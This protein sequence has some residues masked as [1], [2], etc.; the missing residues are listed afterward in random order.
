MSKQPYIGLRPFERDETD[1]FFGREQHSDELVN[2]LGANHFLA[3]IG[4]SG[5]GKSSLVKT[6]LIAGLEAGYLATTGTHWRIVEM[7]PGNRPFKELAEKLEKV[8]ADVL[9]SQ[10]TAET[11]QQTLRQGSLSLHEL[12]A[13]HPLPDKA[14][15]LIVCDQFEEIFRYSQQGANYEAANFVSL[16]LA[17]SKPYPISPKQLS[18]S[19]YVVMTMRSDFLGDCTQFA[20]LSEAINQ[21]LYLTP[22]LD[23]QQLREAI[24]EP[25]L[26]F[27]GIV[28]LGLIT[29]LLEDAENNSDQLPLLQHVLMR[30]WDLAADNTKTLDLEDYNNVGGLKNALSMHADEAYNALS[31]EQKSIAQR[32][33]C[34]LTEHD[35]GKRDTRRPVELS[36]IMSLTEKSCA[37]AVAV[38]DVFRQPG[39]CFLM[40][41]LDVN[42]TPNHII[43]ISHESLI[44]QWQ[45]LKDWTK[46][47]A[48]AAAVYKRLADSAARWHQG[49][50]ALLQSPDLEFA[51]AWQMDFKPSAHWAERYLAAA[52]EKADGGGF[53]SE[54]ASPEK[55]SA[56]TPPTFA[57]VTDYIKRSQAA[58]QQQI[59]QEQTEQQ[60]KLKQ[61]RV[62]TTVSVAGLLIVSAL[63]AEVWSERNHATAIEKQRT[64]ELFQAHLTHASLLAKG[65]DYAE[66]KKILDLTY[67]L[68]KDIAASSQHA[69]NLLAGFT[70]LKGGQAEQVY[71]GA[72]YPLFTVA[73]SPD[74]QLLAA[75][76]EHGTL[77]IFDVQTGKLVQRLEG[78]ATAVINSIVFTPSG[79]QLISGGDD[80]K[81]IVW[82][83]Q[84]NNFSLQNTWLAPD[85]V[86]AVAISPD[87]NTLASGGTD[88]NITLWE[89]VSGKA[90]TTLSR[91]TQTIAV[92]GLSFSA[93]G[94]TLVSSSYDGTAII[95]QVATGTA[96]QVLTGHTDRV[97]PAALSSDGKTL[98]TA[99]DDKTLR[100]WDVD[101]GRTLRVL[102]G[103]KNSV[104]ATRFLANSTYILSGSFDRTIRLWDS[105]TGVALRQWQG[106]DA[107][108]SSLAIY[109]NQLFSAGNDG[110]VRRWSLALPYQLAIALPGEAEANAIA[111]DLSNIVV[112]FADGALRYY[113]LATGRTLWQQQ[114]AH[115]NKIKRLAFNT[116]GD[117]LASGSFDHSA[118][119]WRVV[120]ALPSAPL[121]QGMSLQLQQT[122]TGHTG[123]VNALAFS[124]NSQTVATAGYEGTIG[125]F[126]LGTEKQEFITAHTECQSTECTVAAVS[127][128]KEG[129]Q[130]LSNGT[131]DR[132]VKLWN[133]QT[134]HPSLFKDFPKADDELTWSS[135]SS[136]NQLIST[137]GRGGV[138]HI[139]NTQ[140]NQHKYD[141]PGHE[142]TIYRSIF[143]PDS[144]LLAT[145]G[146][147]ANIKLWNL[148]NGKELLTFRL[149][150]NPYPPVVPMWD[151]DFRCQ[152]T[153]LL[154]VPL[155]AGKL[156][157]Y[158]F[159]YEDK[160]QFANDKAEQKRTSQA[161]WQDYLAMVD[162]LQRQNALPSALQAHREADVI[163]NPLIEAYPDDPAIQE[164]AI[165][166]FYQNAQL[167]KSLNQVPEAL[168]AYLK[169]IEA[170][171]K[172]LK[173]TPNSQKLQT[174]SLSLFMEYTD[175]LKANKQS[176]RA[177]EI[178]QRLFAL[179]LTDVNLLVSRA[180]F[181][182][183]SGNN[184]ALE[185]DLIQASEKVDKQNA[186]QLNN[187]G[188]DLANLTHHYPQAYQLL[189]QAL[190]L[191]PE[192]ANI[193]DSLGWAAYKMGN[194]QE[195][196]DNLQKAYTKASEMS[197]N[198]AAENTT[199][200]GEVFW[201]I[202]NQNQA[203]ELF[204][205]A[206][207]D[208]PDSE[209][210]KKAAIQFARSY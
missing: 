103:H 74:G 184:D 53:S 208:Y 63:A 198:D 35:L 115:E 152:K 143:T 210:V 207:H 50:A 201:A 13:Q 124:P 73:V 114:N 27:D 17:S 69:R 151:F 77:V 62:I 171:E 132:S 8:L 67:P 182:N 60:R 48:E 98:V 150:A 202:G 130:L 161:L 200:L 125:L 70:E 75:A 34:L 55:E 148:D 158:Q 119:V 31:D 20:G 157:L 105:Q 120:S 181:A 91:H 72:G 15:L 44:R 76:G 9:S 79:E 170:S 192:D 186:E 160:L 193:M 164:P 185:H 85:K 58:K 100:L 106:H 28:D 46:K 176:E 42:L 37:E 22:R 4:S 138:V 116:Q 197:K 33:F 159:A 137:V 41:P 123:A 93:N 206:L 133:L 54:N 126:E 144:S 173:Q 167:Q 104:F 12:L 168:T 14:Q 81:I 29:Q 16:L 188:Y 24:E 141:L 82:Q 90:M 169:T 139:Y 146:A 84:Q 66:A 6:G 61:A 26:V 65:E 78:H 87:G 19:I 147:D 39:R 140:S 209:L 68:D 156:L 7:R 153:C 172:S 142:S 174:D 30:L 112:G 109:A 178:L 204:K 162:T 187:V 149:P 1:I 134:V 43:D 45:R 196:L 118:K 95:W 190:A 97:E 18:H 189:K 155:T 129:T 102:T 179:P 122:L 108:I 127:F 99:S 191:K 128:N 47:E 101:T 163:G 71:K 194:N 86:W 180:E 113:D 205:K 110:T 117:L 89:L 5:C 59:E 145:A 57:L 121:A 36:K 10:E 51:L 94:N 83:R 154:A 166:S 177:T 52:A 80:K 111:P 175:Y 32:M 203:T 2:R 56:T 23:A 131:V 88:R 3:V 49:N 107:G 199:H 40:P 92:G 96:L 165:H 195:A 64:T 135:F 25:A 11:L 136:D 21:G 183:Q 38:I